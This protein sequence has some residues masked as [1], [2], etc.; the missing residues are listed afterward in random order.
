ME[1]EEIWENTGFSVINW[2]KGEEI[3]LVGNIC[4]VPAILINCFVH[5]GKN[6]HNGKGMGLGSESLISSS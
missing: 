2:L 4:L 6:D 5:L 1:E 3:Q